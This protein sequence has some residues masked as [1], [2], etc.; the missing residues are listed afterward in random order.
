[1]F[2]STCLPTYLYVYIQSILKKQRNINKVKNFNL[3]EFLLMFLFSP[4]CSH[5]KIICRKLQDYENIHEGDFFLITQ[6][7]IWQKLLSIFTY[8][9][10][11]TYLNSYFRMKSPLVT[12]KK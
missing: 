5:P 2:P 1:M 9:F 6:K 4:F 11:K 3:L 7:N 8:N 10:V 12:C